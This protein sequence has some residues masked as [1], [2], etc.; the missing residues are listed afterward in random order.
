MDLLPGVLLYKMLSYLPLYHVCNVEAMSTKIRS[1]LN[2]HVSNL[3]R[4]LRKDQKDIETE[5]PLSD[6]KRI[7]HK[8]S[9]PMLVMV[10]RYSFVVFNVKDMTV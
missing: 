1:K 2:S 4:Y 6:C 10:K 7:I 9:F 5:L 8:L 3:T